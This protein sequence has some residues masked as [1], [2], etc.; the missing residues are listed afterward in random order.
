MLRAFQNVNYRDLK[1]TLFIL[2]TKYHVNVLQQVGAEVEQSTHHLKV[3]G[4]SPVATIGTCE[5]K[6][7]KKCF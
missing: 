4:L 5:I 2:I 7:L 1:Q 6:K 3:V